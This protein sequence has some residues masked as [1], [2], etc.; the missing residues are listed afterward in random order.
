MNIEKNAAGV[1]MVVATSY[2]IGLLAL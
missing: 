2:E 1:A